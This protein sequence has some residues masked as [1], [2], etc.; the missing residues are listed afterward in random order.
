MSIM[1]SKSNLP[2]FRSLLDDFWNSEKL[3]SNE[4]FN[5]SFPAVNIRENEKDFEIDLA[6]PGFEK[7]DFKIQAENGILNIKAE[8]K[9]ESE[10]KEKSYTRKEFS[11]ESFERRFSIPDNASEEQV[12]ATYE[13]GILKIRLGKITKAAAEKKEIPVQ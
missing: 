13:N 5:S 8:K 9:K 10:E 3:F 4:F 11:Y 1:K 7:N 12:Q 6:S 2:G